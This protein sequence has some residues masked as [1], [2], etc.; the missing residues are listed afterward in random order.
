M[1]AEP[2]KPVPTYSTYLQLKRLL[3][4]QQ[5][6]D[7]AQLAAG[8]DASLAAVRPHA[9]HDEMLFIVVHQVYELWFSLT[10][11]ELTRIRDLLG[12]C[13]GTPRD[14]VSEEDIPRAVN[15]LRRVNEIFQVLIQQ[16]RIMETMNP[17]SFL[18]FRDLITPASGFQSLQF[19]QLEIL[20][21]LSGNL[22]MDFEGKPY[23]SNLESWERGKLAALE[24]GLTLKTALLDWLSRTPIEKVFPQFAERY[25]EAFTGY[26]NEQAALQEN[27][28]NLSAAQRAR[29]IEAAKEQ[30]ANVRNYIL[31]GDAQR[32]RAHQAF[33][34]IASYRHLPLLRWPSALLDSLIEFE[35]NFRLFR[36]RHA[37]MVERMIGARTGTGG[38][39][40]IAYLDSTSNHY[41]IFGDL[42]EARN[43]TLATHRV[44]DLPDESVLGFRFV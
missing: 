21:G 25:C 6:P 8:S 18:E 10:I 38:S 37:R 15:G 4:A 20:A 33:L 24:G 34:F 1:S 32:N 23:A 31:G 39:P 29:A 44:P 5:P 2:A 17:A 16:W 35:Q 13:G 7:Y 19:R 9:H 26:C 14:T 30:S 27:N 22:R 40:G 43:F 28:P 36:F 42:L 3:S 41:K 12:R 11:H